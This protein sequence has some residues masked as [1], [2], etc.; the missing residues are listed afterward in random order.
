M[1]I[2]IAGACLV[3]QPIRS[4]Y[5]LSGVTEASFRYW[6]K[7][8]MA[9][10]PPAMQL[11]ALPFA[12]SHGER[13]LELETPHGY[14]IRVGS[15][16]QAGWL[17]LAPAFQIRLSPVRPPRRS[18]QDRHQ[19]NATPTDPRQQCKRWH[20]GHGSDGKIRRG[21]AASMTVLRG[22]IDVS[23]ARWRNGVSEPASCSRRCTRPCVRRC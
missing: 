9:S 11:I 22:D 8:L 23:A 19:P 3:G 2:P 21:D 12:A 4:W 13:M 10:P 15:Q 5:A 6:R 17:V 16:T 7:R 14:V 20:G 18:K 1:V